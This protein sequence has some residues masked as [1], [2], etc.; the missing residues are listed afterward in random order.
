MSKMLKDRQGLQWALQGEGTAGTKAQSQR[1]RL[2]KRKSRSFC[3]AGTWGR[4]RLAVVIM[5]RG[6]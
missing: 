6:N 2:C 3:L 1:R 5:I 4:D